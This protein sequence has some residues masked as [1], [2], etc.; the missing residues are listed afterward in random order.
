MM[1]QEGLRERRTVVKRR[2]QA[3]ENMLLG[4]ETFSRRS[5]DQRTSLLSW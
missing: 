3:R 4:N 1:T 5:Q 2:L